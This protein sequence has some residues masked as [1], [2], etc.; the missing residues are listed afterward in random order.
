MKRLL[1]PL[2]MLLQ[3]MALSAQGVPFLKNYTPQEYDAHNINFDIKTGTDGTIYVANF[4]GVMYYDH[5]TWNILYNSGITRVTVVYR[6]KN[7]VIWTG[8]YNYF[9][10]VS[11]TENGELYL[12]RVGKP[13]LF[14]G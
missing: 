2:L 11:K 3:V 8:G 9:C 6:D 4:E 14:M 7:D 10:R 5:A 1:I 12:Q 13:D